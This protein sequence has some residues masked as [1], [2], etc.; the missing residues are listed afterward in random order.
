MNKEKMAELEKKVGN[1]PKFC[2]GCQKIF[3]KYWEGLIPPTDAMYKEMAEEMGKYNKNL[4]KHID[5]ISEL[6]DGRNEGEEW[7]RDL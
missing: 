6:F 5:Q 1:P 2:S 7:K 3:D 4:D